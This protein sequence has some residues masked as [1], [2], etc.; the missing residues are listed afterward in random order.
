MARELPLAPLAADE[1]PAVVAAPI[2]SGDGMR[3]GVPAQP[4]VQSR[5][6]AV[7]MAAAPGLRTGGEPACR[8][9]TD[10]AAGKAAREGTQELVE[11]FLASYSERTRLAYATDLED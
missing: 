7:P 9:G 8:V 5:P 11:R 4:A 3:A 6:D 1:A 2:L 10:M